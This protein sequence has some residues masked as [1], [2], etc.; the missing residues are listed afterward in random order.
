MRHAFLIWSVW[1]LTIGPAPAQPVTNASSVEAALIAEDFFN[2]VG[3]QFETGRSTL[4]PHAMPVLD[5]VGEVLVRH[6]SLRLEI[7]G[8][9]DA[10]GSSPLNVRLSEERARSVKAYLMVRHRIDAERLE[11]TGYGA[12][13]PIASNENATGRALNRRVEFR[14]INPDALRSASIGDRS[15]ANSRPVNADSLRDAL[16]R[17]V[18]EAVRDAIAEANPD[19]TELTRVAEL[20]MQLQERLARLDREVAADSVVASPPPPPSS[21]S[22]FAL[23]PF[24]GI[25]LHGDVPVLLGVR[26]DI[27]T[28]LFGSTRFQPEAALGFMP[29][30]HATIVNANLVFPIRI[31]S[32]SDVLPF[33]GAGVGFHNLEGVESVL[34]LLIG[35]E[36]RFDFGVLFAELMTQDFSDFN[37]VIVGFRQDF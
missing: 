30:E 36:Q 27:P 9:T 18:D 6:P 2:A 19:S 35:V 10:L 26:A 22:G 11:T 8:H 3:L 15:H 17:Q 23:L 33:F 20:E 25:Y 31:G 28:A 7:A 37:R 12:S 29:N 13:V 21:G 5:A 14:V 16:Q 32:Y 4:L 24:T 34:N 1:F